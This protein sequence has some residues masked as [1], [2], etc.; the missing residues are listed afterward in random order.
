MENDQGNMYWEICGKELS[1]EDLKFLR[2]QFEFFSDYPREFCTECIGT[3]L[4]EALSRW[5]GNRGAKDHN[6]PEGAAGFNLY[7]QMFLHDIGNLFGMQFL[8]EYIK[9]NP[10]TLKD[11]YSLKTCFWH[12]RELLKKKM[13][14][15][16][17]SVSIGDTDFDA[18]AFIAYEQK[19]ESISEYSLY[20]KLYDEHYRMLLDSYKPWEY[21]DTFRIIKPPEDIP[22]LLRICNF[23]DQG[24]ARGS[25]VYRVIDADLRVLLVKARTTG[26]LLEYYYI[27]DNNMI[28]VTVP[29]EEAEGCLAA[30]TYADSKKL[31]LLNQTTDFVFREDAFLEA[32]TA[33]YRMGK[34]N[35]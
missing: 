29:S 15:N 21:E 12:R 30:Q 25:F 1:E 33:Q 32:L 34:N 11:I 24:N 23:D 27:Q 17:L 28:C 4:D 6:M 22:E 16:I 13:C 20:R 8:I 10:D 18:E 2:S 9:E 7:Q 19:A 14:E 26:R 3:I 35:T 31:T 5:R